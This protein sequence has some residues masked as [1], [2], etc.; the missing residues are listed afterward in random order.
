MKLLDRIFS[1]NV[2]TVL[3]IVVIFLLVTVLAVNAYL[4][5]NSPIKDSLISD[6]FPTKT[7]NLQQLVTR[8]ALTAE[9]NATPTPEP[10]ITTMYFTPQAT[11]ESPTAELQ[12]P[13]VEPTPVPPTPTPTQ[14][15]PT[16]M[17][18]AVT[19][20]ATS[21]SIPQ[22]GD[23]ACI[24]SNPA[25]KG[26][27]LDIVDGITLKVMIDGLTYTVRYIGVAAPADPGYAKAAAYENGKL[28][29]AKEVTLIADAADKDAN[30]RLL[31]YVT[32][33]S[34]FANKEMLTKGLASATDTPPNSSCAQTFSAA[35]QAAKSA[36]AG[37]WAPAGVLP[38]P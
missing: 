6:L 8:A 30:G 28:V 35:E 36:K 29:F 15:A 19:Q 16:P 27:V 18:P 37:Q 34:V 2:V 3:I 11:V 20:A 32:V 31:R 23:M 25:K 4:F 17:Q 5:I 33:G 12:Q 24:P 9:A 22:S 13:T 7:L 1:K 26:R 21:V 38:T 10:T 14:A